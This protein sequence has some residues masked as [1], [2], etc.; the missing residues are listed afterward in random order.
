MS[1]SRLLR[2]VF[3]TFLAAA[4]VL[5]VVYARTL[6]R[7]AFPLANTCLASARIMPPNGVKG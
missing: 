3:G 4:V 7:A 2:L 1:H 5:Q 6:D